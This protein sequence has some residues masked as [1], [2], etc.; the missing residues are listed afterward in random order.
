MVALLGGC[1]GSPY[2]TGLEAEE[3]RKAMLGLNIGMSK[4]EVLQ[5]MG[6]PRKTEA[7]AIEGRNIEFWLY[8]T[9]GITIT[10]RSMGNKNL[11]PLVFENGSLIGWGRSFYDSTLKN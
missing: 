10:D 8:L 3:N 6:E 7:Y 5:V 1:A 9:E 2:Q 11:T 4:T